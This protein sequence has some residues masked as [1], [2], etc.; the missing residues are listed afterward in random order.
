MR[1]ATFLHPGC[2]KHAILTLLFFTGALLLKA[3]TSKDTLYGFQQHISSGTKKVGDIDENGNLIKQKT[4]EVSH[5]SIYLATAS[6]TRIYPIQMWINGEAFSVKI[7]TIE[8]PPVEYSNINAPA[9]KVKP[10]FPE[11]TGTI[12]KLTPTPLVANKGEDK[13][14][15]LAQENAVVLYYTKSG[16][17]Y[18]EILKKFTKL[19]PVSL[20]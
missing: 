14:N 17:K 1:I 9:A 15:A 11:P 10:L 6:K 13:G 18:Y 20:Q 12:Y 7:E 5:Y 2:M 4:P 19:E 3:Q 8:Q 16:K